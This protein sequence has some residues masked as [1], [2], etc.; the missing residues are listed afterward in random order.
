MANNNVKHFKIGT[1]VIDLPSYD[2]SAMRADL[3]AEINNRT[4]ADEALQK[5][6]NSE[7]STRS[8]KDTELQQGINTQKARVDKAFS[9]AYDSA[10]ETITFSSIA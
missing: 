7:A 2:D 8:T 4:A 10:T 9:V 5:N 1:T 6:I 3:N